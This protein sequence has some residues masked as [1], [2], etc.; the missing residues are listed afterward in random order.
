MK[1][2][3][4]PNP[5]KTPVSLLAVLVLSS[6]LSCAVT[7]TTQT[8]DADQQGQM[9]RR[10]ASAAIQEAFDQ[11]SRRDFA[12]AMSG[13]DNVADSANAN[14]DDQRLAHLG[15]SLV[16]LST[17]REWR[18]LDAAAMALQSAEDIPGGSNPVQHGMLVNAVSSLIGAEKNN[19]ELKGKVNNA[20]YELGKLK[21]A[22]ENQDAEVATLNEAL[23]KLKDLT[24]GN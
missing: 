20:A 6:G 22:L 18:D 9:S 19:A 1:M 4:S 3:I 5:F 14:P 10:A 13:F 8:Q 2:K 7:P 16:Y 12:T 17:D 24:I 15:K 21:E 23:E 11:F